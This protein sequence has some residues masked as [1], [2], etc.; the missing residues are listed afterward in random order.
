MKV[1]NEQ[2]KTEAY[3]QKKPDN[4]LGFKQ[5]LRNI[6]SGNSYC[7]LLKWLSIIIIYLSTIIGFIVISILIARATM[8]FITE[9]NVSK[10]IFITS[11]DTDADSWLSFLGSA[12][13]AIIPLVI[14][15]ITY[16]QNEKH[17]HNSFKQQN[18]V[19][20]WQ[21]KDAQ[22]RLLE[23]L[24]VENNTVFKISR[25]LPAYFSLYDQSSANLLLEQIK[26]A[27]ECISMQKLKNELY[28]NIHEKD[29]QDVIDLYFKLA[30]IVYY[31][32]YSYLIS[33]ECIA[34]ILP[35]I[36]NS[37][38]ENSITNTRILCINTAYK[39]IKT[40]YLKTNS[41][42]IKE[43][44][45]LFTEIS[46][47]INKQKININDIKNIILYLDDFWQK[48]VFNSY[49]LSNN[50]ALLKKKG[51]EYLKYKCEQLTTTLEK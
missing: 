2:A 16:K 11:T 39:T 49:K 29:K 9:N 46:V 22:F 33:L 48:L 23:D 8:Y 50:T 27:K 28:N 13:A 14:L 17:L 6:N 47:I 40:V 34:I 18:K 4:K 37:N 10:Q 32:H 51:M 36:Y 7:S 42:Y 12:I 38:G 45:L 5:K 31:E 43:I 24:V 3:N 20:S 15:Y 25:Y 1:Q 19:L 26:N 35:E 41:E 21:Y 30:E 44:M